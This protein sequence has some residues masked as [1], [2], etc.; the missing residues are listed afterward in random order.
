MNNGMGW[1]LI[2]RFLFPAPPATY[3]ADSFPEELIFV[4]K[5]LEQKDDCP[6]DQCVPCLLLIYP[7]ARFLVFYLHSNAEDLGQC[8]SFCSLIREQLQVHVLAVEYPGYGICPGGQATEAS[9]TA[10]AFAAFRFVRDILNWPLDSIMI[11]GRSIGTGPAISLAVQYFVCGV[12]LVAPFSSIKDLLNDTIGHLLTRMIDERFPNKDRMPH[13]RS[14][15]LI[16]HGRR[17]ELIPCRHGHGLYSSCRSRKLLVCPESMEHNT[18]LLADLGYLVLPMLQFFPL[19]DY[20]FEDIK[21]PKW[22]FRRKDKVKSSTPR[23]NGQH[24]EGSEENRKRLE[25][26]EKNSKSSTIIRGL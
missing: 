4:P 1:D 5:K 3:T 18:N 13:I 12:V 11:F 23:Q 15:V 10:N 19:P 21:I 7:F 17:D 2:S 8:Y 24:A 20:C 6:E 22:A 9:V 14:P 16:V 26:G 25:N